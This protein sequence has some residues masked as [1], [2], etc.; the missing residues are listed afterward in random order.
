M[1]DISMS[2]TEK[3]LADVPAQDPHFVLGVMAR[4]EQRR[5]RRELART[6]GLCAVAI[7]LLALVM[8]GLDIAMGSMLSVARVTGFSHE[9]GGTIAVV[10][11]ALSFALPRLVQR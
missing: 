7:L 6:L 2:E 4:I 5:F 3:F 1:A 9:F 10:L 11:I 8:P